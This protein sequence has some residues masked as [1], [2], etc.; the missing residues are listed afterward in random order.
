MYRHLPL[1]DH[2]TSYPASRAAECAGAQ[3]RFWQIHEALYLSS[4]WQYGS[5]APV[6]EEMAREVGVPDMSAFSRCISE[7]DPV[8][9]ISQDQSV[10]YDSGVSGTPSFIINGR[11]YRGVVDSLRFD[12]IFEEL[13]R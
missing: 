13:A 2:D 1:G 12:K 6:F 8:S 5:A 11:W 3:D 9:A 4:A 7:E 10:A